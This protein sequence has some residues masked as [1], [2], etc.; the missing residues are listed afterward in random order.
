MK[1]WKKHLSTFSFSLLAV[2]SIG[3]LVEFGPFWQDF[4]VL[5]DTRSV[6]SSSYFDGNDWEIQ[7]WD[8]RSRYSTQNTV[9]DRNIT[10]AGPVAVWQ[11]LTENGWE[12]MFW[13]VLEQTEFQLTTNTVDDVDPKTDGR[14]LVWR[15]Q[16]EGVWRVMKMDLQYPEQDPEQL[17]FVGSV[18]EVVISDGVVAWQE[19]IDDSW[20]IMVHHIDGASQ[21]ITYNGTADINPQLV[22]QYVYYE[23]EDLEG[24]DREIYRFDLVY[25]TT[26][27]VTQNEIDD[28]APQ[29]FGEEI[30]WYERRD[31]ISAKMELDD[32]TGRPRIVELIP[33][34]AAL[35]PEQAVE[36]QEIAEEATGDVVE[37]ESGEEVAP[38]FPS[39][40]TSDGRAG[41]LGESSESVQDETEEASSDSSVLSD[42]SDLSEPDLSGLEES[43]P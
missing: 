36:L 35:T 43:T 18:D 42:P 29:T 27:S 28:D 21:R 4:F 39:E 8:F 3:G 1:K 33:Q 32:V 22:D 23:G 20:E 40:R 11:R 19:W 6:Q 34:A 7:A 2:S 10:S 5:G 12:L 14:Y 26:E 13:S 41:S 38:G 31:G 37:E 9:D 25:G 16:V 17:S 30:Q 24:G 15:S